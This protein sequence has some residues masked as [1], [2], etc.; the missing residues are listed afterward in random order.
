M[1]RR[2][3][4]YT[5]KAKTRASGTPYWVVSGTID[6]KQEKPEFSSRA[7][8]LAFLEKRNSQLRGHPVEQ[9]PVVTRLSAE[10]VKDAE[11]ALLRLNEHE[12][13]TRLTRAVE[14]YR[15]LSGVI[16]AT[17]A[18][19]AGAAM[20]EVREKFPQATWHDVCR[21]YVTH[22]QAPVANVTLVHAIER[23]LKD[24]FRRCDS[25]SLSVWQRDSVGF[26]MQRLE[27]HFTQDG[28]HPAFPLGD[29]NT[30]ALHEYLITVLRAKDGSDSFS[31]KSWNNNR[32]YL[33]NFFRFCQRCGWVRD[34]PATGLENYRRRELA[35]N[36]PPLIL[37]AQQASELMH[38]V[39]DNHEA[40]LVPFVALALFAGIRP[41]WPA[42]EIAK[43][44]AESF[45]WNAGVIR[46]NAVDTKTGR[47]RDVV[48]RPNLLAWLKAYPV[49]DFPIIPPN[50][51]KLYAGLKERFQLG[52]DV[53]RH[54]YCS[55]LVGIDN[56]VAKAAL[57]A[58]NSESVLWANYLHLV[59]QKEAEEFWKI[60]PRSSAAARGM[61]GPRPQPTR[62][63]RSVESRDR[64]AEVMRKRI[65]EMKK[66]G[67]QAPVATVLNRVKLNLP[68]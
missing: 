40:R 18:P 46:L 59:E 2:C 10:Q 48:M 58:G 29:I 26:A 1:A 38:Y 16:S 63:P 17:E 3:L 9:A 23:Y 45:V 44:R 11:I 4:G 53:L 33:T 41:T 8:A 14:F 37:R 21:Y 49:G 34:N 20:A 19:G 39:E 5:L 67:G 32:G 61:S 6:G 24:V 56:S 51:R 13:A 66:A 65:R 27:K 47:P 22:Y 62:K 64:L 28:Q 68:A 52:Y 15:E 57:Q 54:T 43:I 25:K 60:L 42:G 55:M 36:G 50:F 35:R 30:G 7:E 12:P 31:N